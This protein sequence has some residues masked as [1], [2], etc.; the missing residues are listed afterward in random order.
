MMLALPKLGAV[1]ITFAAA[2]HIQK[3]EYKYLKYLDEKI[4]LLVFYI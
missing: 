3:I 4:I 2:K 1:A